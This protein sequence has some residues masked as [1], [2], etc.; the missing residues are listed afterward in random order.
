MKAFLQGDSSKEWREFLEFHEQVIEFQANDPIWVQGDAVAGLHSIIVG[1]VK[2]VVEDA[3]EV[4]LVRLAGN[5]DILGHRGLGG[6]WIYPVSAIALVPTTVCFLPLHAFEVVVK[7]NA[8]LSYGMMMFLA[9]ELRVSEE[10][11]R[12]LPV[13]NRVSR[14]LL[15]NYHAFG[16]ADDGNVLSFTI[17]RKDIASHASTTYESAI[18]ALADL[19][20]HKVI[21]LVGKSIAI[22]DLPRLVQLASSNAEL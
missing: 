19:S 6:N 10:N 1:K 5:G 12:S 7:T 16:F 3:G 17:S 2:V 9:E 15:M 18:R 21:D 14:T 22:L 8:M 20:K 4:H 11:Q 13:L